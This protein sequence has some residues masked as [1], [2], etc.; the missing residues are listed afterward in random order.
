MGNET[1]TSIPKDYKLNGFNPCDHISI[2]SIEW[3]YL[4]SNAKLLERMDLYKWLDINVCVAVRNR[5]S[6]KIWERKVGVADFMH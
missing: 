3:N 2:V 4:S 6:L 1:L 5:Q